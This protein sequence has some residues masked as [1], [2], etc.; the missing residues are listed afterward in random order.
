ML[1]RMALKCRAIE[2]F[3]SSRSFLLLLM[4]GNSS[5]FCINP[6]PFYFKWGSHFIRNNYT[7]H[8]NAIVLSH[9]VVSSTEITFDQGKHKQV[10][11]DRKSTGTLCLDIWIPIASIILPA[12]I[13]TCKLSWFS[14][15]KTLKYGN[16]I[17]FTGFRNKLAFRQLNSLRFIAVAFWIFQL[18][19]IRFFFSLKTF[20]MNISRIVNELR[21]KALIVPANQQ[22]I[23]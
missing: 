18:F 22:A 16:L 17:G 20:S 5:Y 3:T 19:W 15:H 2:R 21:Q 6:T 12:G 13:F 10:W 14:M 9:E 11:S 8:K 7:E 1:K 4:L 23:A